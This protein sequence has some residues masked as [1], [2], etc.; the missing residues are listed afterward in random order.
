MVNNSRLFL[1]ENRKKS[2]ERLKAIVETVFK[3]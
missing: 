2:L 1:G 3:K